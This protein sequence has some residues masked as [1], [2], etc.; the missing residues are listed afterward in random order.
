MPAVTDLQE[1]MQDSRTRCSIS[2]GRAASRH[3]SVRFQLAAIL[4]P[5]ASGGDQ[6]G[7]LVLDDIGDQVAVIDIESQRHRMSSV[8]SRTASVPGR[9]GRSSI[10]FQLS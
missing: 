8:F 7:D 9:C 4:C 2:Q 10:Y 3:R 5:A 6:D 1:F